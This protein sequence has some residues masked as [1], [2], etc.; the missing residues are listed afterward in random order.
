M[1]YFH[2]NVMLMKDAGSTV[3]EIELLYHRK[4]NRN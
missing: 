3:A 4:G 1:K 2:R